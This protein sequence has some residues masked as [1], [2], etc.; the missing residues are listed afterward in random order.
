MSK[1]KKKKMKK[2]RKKQR[3]L[4]EQQ[5]V[6]LEGLAVGSDAIPSAIS[7]ASGDVVKVCNIWLTV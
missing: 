5:L 2:K 7:S 1:N 3:E 4:L 6:Q